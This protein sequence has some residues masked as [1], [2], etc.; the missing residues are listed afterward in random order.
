MQLYDILNPQLFKPLSGRNQWIFADLLMLIWD[1]CR[2]STDYGMG[3]NEMIRLTED[4]LEGAGLE[5]T[6]LDSGEQAEENEQPTSRDLHSKTVWCIARLRN[7]GWLEDLEIGYEE[8]ARTAICPRVVPIL[9]AFYS[10]VHPQTVTYSGKLNKAYQLLSGI[11]TEKAPYENILK[12]V[13]SAMDE[14][15]SALRNLNASIGSFIDQMTQHKTPQE[16]LDLFEKYEEEIVVAAYQ[17]FK[18]SD[19]LFNYREALLEGLDNCQDLY[20]DALAADYCKVE[21]CDETEAGGAILRII[22]RIR[23][24]LTLMGE[25]IAEIDKNHITY[26][27][28]AVQ[29]AQFMLLTDGTTQGRIN[30]LLRYYAQTLETP[31]S[32]FDV[33]DSPLSKLWRIYPTEILGRSYLKPPVTSRKPTPIEPLKQSDTLDE[34]ELRNAQ[35][36]LGIDLIAIGRAAWNN[37]TTWSLREGG[38]T[39]TQQLAKNMYFTQEKSFIRKVAEMFVAFQLEHTYT[40]DEILELY[41]NSIYFGDGY[42]GIGDA[43]KGYLNKAPIEMTNYECTLMAGIPNAPSVYSLTENP[44]LAEQRQKYVVRQMAKYGYITEDQAQSIFK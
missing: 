32:L 6:E 41:V 29:R 38:S 13:A 31:A 33:D 14:L 7:C 42:Y 21:R 9:Q 36:A 35:Q 34:Q 16:V 12:E 11:S 44:T 22:D 8:E 4:Y 5:M 20:I 1:H 3:K 40:K 27:Q 2:M 37:L 17:R 26:R 19:N 24:D 15:N 25:L 39:I 18:T 28:R 10:I 30:S 43:C 23:D